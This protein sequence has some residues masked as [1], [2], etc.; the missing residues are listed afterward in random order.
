MRVKIIIMELNDSMDHIC[1]GPGTFCSQS[2][3]SAKSSFRVSTLGTM[4]HPTITKH[5]FSTISI[6]FLSKDTLQIHKYSLLNNL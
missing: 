4:I 6:A 1:V 3:L 2:M 5:K